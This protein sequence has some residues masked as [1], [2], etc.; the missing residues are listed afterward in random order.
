[1][2]E[3]C[4]FRMLLTARD[5]WPNMQ[6]SVLVVKEGLIKRRPEAVQELVDVT[7]NATHWINSNP[8]E[9]AAIL[10]RQLSAAQRHIFPTKVAGSVRSLQIT[11]R[12]LLKSM[13][14]LDYE[15]NITDQGVQDIIDYVARLGYI[16]SPF[17]AHDILDLRFLK[18]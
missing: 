16:A 8:N 14:R 17:P 18:Q 7:R 3:A 4:G 13:A 11:P 1:M 2:A 5:L 9:A 10:A 12:V 6:G 15:T